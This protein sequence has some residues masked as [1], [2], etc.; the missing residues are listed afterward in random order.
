MVAILR[1][2]CAFKA[3]GSHVEPF[4]MNEAVRISPNISR[5][6]L[7]A[8]PSVPSAILKPRSD[9]DDIG[10]IPP[11][12]LRLDSGWDNMRSGIF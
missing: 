11:P 5:S 4:A 8:A 3:V 10:A 12:S 2:E 1:M 7:L 9:K 6:L